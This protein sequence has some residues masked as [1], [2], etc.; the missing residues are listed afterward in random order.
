LEYERSVS[1]TATDNEPN[2]FAGSHR[3]REGKECGC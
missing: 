3:G 1:V 2:V